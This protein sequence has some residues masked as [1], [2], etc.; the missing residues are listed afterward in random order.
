M[1]PMRDYPKDFAGRVTAIPKGD[2]AASTAPAGVEGTPVSPPH[3]SRWKIQPIEFLMANQIGFAEANVIKY[4]C[5][6]DAKNGAE[7]LLKARRYIDYILKHRY[8]AG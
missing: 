3:Y 5:R 2:H 8:N 7:D 6:H 4:V 1:D